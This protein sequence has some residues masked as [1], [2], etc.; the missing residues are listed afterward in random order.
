MQKF[1]VYRL[2]DNTIL[3]RGVARDVTIQGEEGMGVALGHG[4]QDVHYVVN[5]WLRKLPRS[6]R[7]KNWQKRAMKKLR[8]KR[9]AHLNRMDARLN[10]AYWETLSEQEKQTWHDYRQALLDLPNITTNPKNVEWPQPPG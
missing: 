7:K 2:S 6:V 10:A 9:N 8:S 1:T 4:H 5:G 3:Y